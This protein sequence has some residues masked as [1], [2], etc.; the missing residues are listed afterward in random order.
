MGPAER[1]AVAMASRD[2]DAIRPLLAPGVV[3]RSP[4]TSSFTFQGPDEILEL[5]RVV[6]D[7]YE[8]LEYTDVFGSGDTW[9]Q[10]FKTR[11]RGQEM[12]GLDL[13][14]L[15]GEGRVEEF[16]VFFRPL[17]GL[18]ALTAGLAPP[19]AAKQGDAR[20]LAAKL[21]TAPLVPLTRFGDRI[22]ARL[23]GRRPGR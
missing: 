10:V 14:R 18:A 13:M 11:V 19:L 6:R 4:I 12:E 21:L 23:V 16:T 3:L 9:V 8:Q 22:A 20:G 15:D 1:M 2:F 5:L 7:A 17:P